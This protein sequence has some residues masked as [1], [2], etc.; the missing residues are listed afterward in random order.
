MNRRSA[1]EVLKALQFRIA[2]HLLRE[3]ARL[4]PSAGF[5]TNDNA[6]HNLLLLHY[7][8]NCVSKAQNCGCA[9]TQFRHQ[10]IRC[11]FPT[12]S[13][14]RY[15]SSRK[16]KTVE[17]SPTA[18]HILEAVAILRPELNFEPLFVRLRSDWVGSRSESI[19][20]SQYR[21]DCYQWQVRAM[22]HSN[23]GMGTSRLET[24]P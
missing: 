18:R 3:T 9:C 5:S 20:P 12:T 1:P 8:Q 17:L 13:R 2:E 10:G 19:K 21:Q 15:A 4:L 16:Q 14:K 22:P 7:T 24:W 23:P 6:C 11:R